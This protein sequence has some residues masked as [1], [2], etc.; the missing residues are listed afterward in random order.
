MNWV[1]ISDLTQTMKVNAKIRNNF[2][3]KPAKIIPSNDDTVK[4]VF[5]EPQ[6]AVTPGQAVVFYNDDIVIGGGIIKQKL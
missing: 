4:V 5:D 6:K 1:A 3:E 2:S